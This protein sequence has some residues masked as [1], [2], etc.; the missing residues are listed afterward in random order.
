MKR[1]NIVFPFVAAKAFPALRVGAAG[2]TRVVHQK[3]SFVPAPAV[4]KTP[5][6]LCFS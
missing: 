1:F 4:D 2:L 5:S 3:K 6:L